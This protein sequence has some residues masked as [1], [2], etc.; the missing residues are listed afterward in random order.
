[1]AWSMGFVLVSDAGCRG[2]PGRRVTKLISAETEFSLPRENILELST[3]VLLPRHIFLSQPE[4]R[5]LGGAI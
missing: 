3:K 2:T 4:F 1:M 5:A